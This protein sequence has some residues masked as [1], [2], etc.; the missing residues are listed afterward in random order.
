[1][2]EPYAEIT[3]LVERL[4]RRYLDVLRVEL[5][6]LGVDDISAAQ[7]MLVNN[8]GERDLAV[9]DLQEQGYYMGS[10]VAYNIKKLVESGYIAQERSAR[11][12]RSVRIKLSDKGRKL[13]ERLKEA[14]ALLAERFT[15]DGGESGLLTDACTQLR[16]IE[17]LWSDFIQY[18]AD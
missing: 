4:H 14:D 3:R 13:N 7:A 15:A 11:D 17:R 16:A 12:R 9:R 8:L 2:A 5:Q 1:M 10:N 18:G 6:R